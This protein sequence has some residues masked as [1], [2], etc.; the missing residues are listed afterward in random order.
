VRRFYETAHRDC[1]T[2]YGRLP[3]PNR[4]PTPKQIQTLVQ[5]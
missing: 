1:Q 4:L 5:V 3:T 2:L